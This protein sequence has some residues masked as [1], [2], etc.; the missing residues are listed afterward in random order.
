MVKYELLWYMKWT[1]RLSKTANL[2][3]MKWYIMKNWAE[4]EVSLKEQNL[5]YRF[6]NLILLLKQK[7][8]YDIFM[9]YLKVVEWWLPCHTTYTVL[10]MYTSIHL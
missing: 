2:A 10:Y 3:C 7:K 8:T 5:R 1:F 4:A 9:M 6:V